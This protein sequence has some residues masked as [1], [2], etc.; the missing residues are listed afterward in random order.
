MFTSGDRV[1]VDVDGLPE[2]ATV[3]AAIP[4]P[5]GATW[6]VF[7][8]DDN[9]GIHEVE[10]GADDHPG[11]V[12]KIATDG[13]AKSPRVL[14][15]MWTR[16]M[17]AAAAN[18][19]TSAIAST[20]LRPYPHQTTA[21]YGA[22]LPQPM[23]RFLLA[24]E[25]GTGKTIMAGLYLREMQRLGLVQRAIVVCPANLA[26]KWVADFYRFF[27]GGMRQLTANTVREEAVNS[28][29]LWVVS[30]ELAA[31]NPAVQDAIRPDR[32]GWDLVIFDE[33]HRLTPTATSYHQV[34]RLLAANT[35]RA[36]LMTATPHRGK[37][38]LFR[39]LLHLVDP[40]I[41]PDPGD[42]PQV[43]LPALRPGPTHFL[44]RMKEDLV[45]YDGKTRLFKGRT[46]ENYRVP[47][48]STEFSYYQAALDMVDQYFQPTAQPLARMVYGKRTASSLWA[49][50]E[51]LKRRAA[52]MGEMSE[53]EAALKADAEN[54]G[55][56]VEVDEAKVV[57]AGSTASRAERAAIKVLIEQIT[58]TIND[59]SYRPSKW[60]RL[61]EN[62]LKD[63]G[64]NPGNGEQAV[65]FTEYADSAE[66][67]TRRLE[68]DGYSARMYS[69]R[70]SNAERDAARVAFMRGDYQVIVTTDAGNEGIDLQAAHVLV[71]YDIPW[72]LVRLEQRMGRIHRVGQMRDVFL[73]NLVAT[74]T[75]EGDTLFVLLNNF[76]TAANELRG[77][78][79]DSLSAVAEIT[80]VDYEK[81]LTDL[82][83]NDEAKKQIALAAAKA[84]QAQEITRAARQVRDT[85]RQLASQVDAVAALT[86]L[87]RDL[88]ARINPAIVEKY[89]ER[90]TAADLLSAQRTAIGDGF[91]QLVAVTGPFPT[92]LGGGESILVA[93]SGEAIRDNDS[94]VDTAGMITLG[95]G[96]PAFAD[97]IGLAERDLAPDLHQGGAVEDPTSLTP[98]DLYAFEATMTESDG[99]RSSAWATLIKVD[100]SG[101]ARAIRWETLANLVASGNAGTAPHPARMKA[102]SSMAA[103]VAEETLIEHSR[104]RADWFARARRDLENLPIA[105]TDAIKSRTERISLRKHLQLQT[106][107]RLEQLEKLSQVAM[108]EPKLSGRVRVLPA[109]TPQ[110]EAQASS[111]WVAMRHVQR[112]LEEDGWTVDDVHTESRGYDLDARRHSEIRHIEV[113]G[114]VG[115]AASTGI[116]MTGNEVLIATQHRKEYWLY[117]VDQCVDGTG[118]LFGA[119]R[120][121][122]TLFGSDMVGDAIFRVPGGSLKN[123]PGSNL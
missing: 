68:A 23:L 76:V 5:S 25:P 1:L 66:W 84:V 77:Q 80:G 57:H 60:Q 37:E 51:T 62:C 17:S 11:K 118:R 72:S 121:P 91:R 105:L 33:A 107:K 4:S 34:G 78:V 19:E 22:M 81:W 49:L 39:H 89:L 18:A 83:G 85:E 117:V 9:G 86:L 110:T 8:L 98:Y 82:Y 59:P 10:L 70:Q 113:K 114:V 119:Y 47:L 122:A 123:A 41:F 54:E 3:R 35:P 6:T 28:H 55:D 73:Y 12:A 74:D 13:R 104:V 7:L 93:T 30:L 100:D 106:T 103:T 99:K 111:E 108:T 120:D 56:D 63:N 90:L 79:F 40:A 42:D 21:V 29:N 88:F 43:T 46:A 102:A 87:Q 48:S 75:R 16:W 95:P 96:E 20:Q 36:L 109:G 44:R 64:I 45:D 115:D 67:I 15:G 92:S 26:S 61:I 52:H 24:D 53:A 58:A 71:N 14:A 69:G 116:R 32:A 97:L 65:V 50:T 31:V 38:W 27:G 94:I 101:N 112:V 2:L